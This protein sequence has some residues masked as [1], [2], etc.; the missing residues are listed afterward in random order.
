MTRLPASRDPLF[1]SPPAATLGVPSGV[2]DI[3]TSPSR[4]P[5]CST[6]VNA[7]T[8]IRSADKRAPPSTIGKWCRTAASGLLFEVF[9]LAARGQ[10]ALI[11]IVFDPQH[12]FP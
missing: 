8:A 12:V 3:A 1:G 6:P 5:T 4:R 7:G 10:L 2:R 9:D 11:H